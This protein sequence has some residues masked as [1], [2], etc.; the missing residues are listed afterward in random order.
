MLMA[1]RVWALPQ[2]HSL[3]SRVVLLFQ[4]DNV[5]IVGLAPLYHLHLSGEGASQEAGQLLGLGQL[6]VGPEIDSSHL[7]LVPSQ[8]K[9]ELLEEGG[10]R[11]GG[12]HK[13]PVQEGY[14]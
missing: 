11:G 3:S 9:Q 13:F 8:T 6:G 10:K 1:M 5:I 14:G 7:P 12:V 2:C 4:G